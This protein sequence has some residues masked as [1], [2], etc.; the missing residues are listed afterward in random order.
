[1][2][3]GWLKETELLELAKF[4]YE[5]Y[6]TINQSIAGRFDPRVIV[7]CLQVLELLRN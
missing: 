3:T 5:Q 6:A 4:T 7:N 2:C 1:M